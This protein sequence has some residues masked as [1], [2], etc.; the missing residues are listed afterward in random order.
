MAGGLLSV[1]TSFPNLAGMADDKK[2]NVLV[3][4]QYMLLEELRYLM[5]NLG[6]DNFN[7]K[8]LDGLV[9]IIREPLRIQLED[10]E[11]GWKNQLDITAQGLQAQISDN[12]G[13]I[14]S[15]TATSQGLQSSVQ[16]LDGRLTV[17]QQTADGASILASNLNGEWQ[18]FQ[19]NTSGL[20]VTGP[21]G[22]T[23][24]S[25]GRVVTDN[26]FVKNIY[27]Q[28]PNLYTGGYTDAVDIKNS[29]GY[30][31]GQITAESGQTSLAKV[32]FYGGA[33]EVGSTQGNIFL[34]AA[35]RA[36]LM[37]SSGSDNGVPRVQIGGAFVV[38]REVYGTQLPP[39]GIDGQVFFLIGG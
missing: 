14:T 17:V 28:N 39:R 15:L 37:V 22:Q 31:V 4:Y 34:N 6:P 21:G 13:N 3:D 29:S 30:T 10:A 9:K 26:L 24:V 18:Q 36:S 16:S 33:V 7:D 19:V 20:F 2:I 1:D 35:R 23:M 11:K 5:A 32:G 12:S 8:E 27:G 25:G 38:N